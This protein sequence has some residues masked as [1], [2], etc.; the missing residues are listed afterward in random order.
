MTPA[1]RQRIGARLKAEREARGW[2]QR[3]VA[4]QLAA[5]LPGPQIPDLGTLID[6]VKRWERGRA[7]VG[8]RHQE[9]LAEIFSV[10]R[11][12]FFDLTADAEDDPVLRRNFLSATATIG[13]AISPLSDSV[14]PGRRIGTGVVD[15]LHRRTARLRRL[16]DVLGGADTYRI[17]A[18]ELAATQNLMKNSSYS[19]ATGRQLLGVVAEQAQQAG[20]AALDA[21]N[22]AS[23]R[24]LFRDSMTAAAESGDTAL[25]AN[26]LALMSYQRV[27]AGSRG[28]N[29]A[30]AACRMVDPAT[31]AP[32][33]AL[34]HERAA[35]AHAMAGPAHARLVEQALHSARS[36]IAG[37]PANGPDWARWVDDVELQIMTGRCW[38]ILRHPSR[39]IP[40]LTWALDR[41]PDAHARD[42][43]LYLSWLADAHV[44]AREIDRA[45]GALSR[46]IGLGCD[47]ASARPMT[48]VKAVVARLRPHAAAV[49]V[50]NVLEEART[51]TASLS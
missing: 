48:R 43:S 22:H 1:E 2:T 40:A 5:A 28:T 29:E 38:T 21:G 8:P 44:E 10:P 41:Y 20:W 51:M 4:D 32:V 7:G 31:P 18:A 14:Q 15:R 47:L 35:W 50:R 39:A 17:Y 13:L 9:A 42:K 45:A 3:E 16:D 30:D 25:M 24:T 49:A 46:A 23:A 12:Q 11:R 33:Q 37:Q 6:Y 19:E 36:A 26:A 27:S 34:L